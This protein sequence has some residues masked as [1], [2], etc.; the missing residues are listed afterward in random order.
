M[1][2]LYFIGKILIGL[3]S[4]KKQWVETFFEDLSN[5]KHFHQ[6]FMKHNH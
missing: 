4:Y 6:M 2:L 1:L 3:P 5:D